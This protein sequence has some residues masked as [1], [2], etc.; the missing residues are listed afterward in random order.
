MWRI[1]YNRKGF[2]LNLFVFTSYFYVFMSRATKRSLIIG[3]YVGLLIAVGWSVYGA[4]KP[5]ETC[6]D[7][8]QNQNEAG[9]D[10]GGV[11]GACQ[12]I[13]P[14]E[15]LE[16]KEAAFMDGGSNR[17]DVL[18]RVYNPN[19]RYGASQFTYTFSVKDESGKV[20]SERTGKSFILP[21]ETKYIVESNLP[22]EATAQG[23]VFT[24][25]SDVQ[26]E[27]FSGYR[28]APEFKIS[29]KSADYISSGTGFFRAFG[30]LSNESGFDFQSVTVNVVLR[31][32]NNQPLAVNKTE[33]RT[34]AAGERRDVGPLV[35]YT[36][37]PGNVTK[38]DMEAEAD[39]YRA[40]NFIR[41]Y[42]PS[43]KIPGF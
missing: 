32:D 7:G 33:L 42:V 27:V 16:V 11:C 39:V 10:C 12:P 5:A 43:A 22:S 15:N 26:W 34:I 36:P 38:M 13:L 1:C 6:T 23:V 18:A 3:V 31:D 2:H 14:A 19:D 17:Y 20:I 8:K 21:K 9:I 37:F 35:W 30:T 24:L 25:K 41:Q 4:W 28:Q 29:S 40:D